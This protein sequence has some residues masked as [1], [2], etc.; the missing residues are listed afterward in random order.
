MLKKNFYIDSEVIYNAHYIPENINQDNKSTILWV[1]RAHPMKRPEIFLK[2]AKLFPKEKF[3]MVM[4]LSKDYD[5][6]FKSIKNKARE[7]DNLEFITGVP[8][9]KIAFY[10]QKAKLF[11]LTSEVEGFSNVLIEALKIKTPVVSLSV[12][13]DDILV[14]NKIGFCADGNVNKMVKY[15]TSLL[16]DKE[17]WQLYSDRA[18][19][20]TKENF[21]MEKIIKKY[22][23]LLYEITKRN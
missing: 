23:E 9:N 8:H 22:K 20:F 14:N 17:L 2:L 18:Y 10:Y 12:D 21:D 15:I 11:I 16:A 4:S 13:P 6:L 7:I 1:G 5:V 19:N 3:I